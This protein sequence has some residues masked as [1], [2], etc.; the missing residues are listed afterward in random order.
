MSLSSYNPLSEM[1]SLRD[2]MNRL[3]EESYVRPSSAGG[4][5]IPLDVFETP[6]DLVIIAAVPGASADD[7]NV[8]ATGDTVTLKAKVPSETQKSQSSE[9][10]WYLHEIPHGE[11]TR[12][13]DLPVEINPQNG[14]ATFQNGMLRLDLPKVE[15][16]R[17]HKLNIQSGSQAQGQ[18]VNAGQHFEGVAKGPKP[19]VT[20]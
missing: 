15:E 10:T 7:V 12:M 17:Q 20:Q 19:G 16:A 6:D 4:R 1:T 14:K 5:N 18:K 9:W 2:A 3:L 8:T 11:F 13:I